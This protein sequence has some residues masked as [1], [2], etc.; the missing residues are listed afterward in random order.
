L[1]RT[2]DQKVIGL[3]VV[4]NT[5]CPKLGGG[6]LLQHCS[7]CSRSATLASLSSAASSPLA[8]VAMV[9]GVAQFELGCVQT[10]CGSLMLRVENVTG[11]RVTSTR[12]QVLALEVLLSG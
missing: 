1:A 9:V 6:L 5:D 7:N 2:S 8:I 11:P 3:N 12:T 10:I 4:A